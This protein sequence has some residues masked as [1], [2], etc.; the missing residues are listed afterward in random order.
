MFTRGNR[1]P[2]EL[3]F[4]LVTCNDI[5]LYYYDPESRQVNGK[6]AHEVNTG[7]RSSKGLVLARR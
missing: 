6:E 2:E 5:W 1:G 7:P 3:H 4:R